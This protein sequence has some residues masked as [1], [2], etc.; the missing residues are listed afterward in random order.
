MELELYDCVS[1][2][3][4]HH[5]HKPWY[6]QANA[7]NVKKNK[8]PKHDYKGM[9]CVCVFPQVSEQTWVSLRDLIPII[10]SEK[11]FQNHAR[12][13]CSISDLPHN[14]KF[15]SISENRKLVPLS[16][17]ENCLRRACLPEKKALHE[18]QVFPLQQFCALAVKRMKKRI[19]DRVAERQHDSNEC[20][21]LN[22]C[23]DQLDN[24]EKTCTVS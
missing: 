11:A 20:S 23:W 10:W 8:Q 4:V 9:V 21:L 15:G 16:F 24:F 17:L 18:L 2:K 19:K 6:M 14:G 12:L 3:V 1:V 5:Q 22:V 13:M 7:L